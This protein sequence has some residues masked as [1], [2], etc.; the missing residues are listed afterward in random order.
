MMVQRNTSSWVNSD[1]RALQRLQT[2]YAPRGVPLVFTGT[3]KAQLHLPLGLYNE[4]FETT[5][6]VLKG[7]YRMRWGH[8]SPPQQFSSFE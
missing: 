2:A 8:Q 3:A 1:V 7:D 4:H 5:M 6:L